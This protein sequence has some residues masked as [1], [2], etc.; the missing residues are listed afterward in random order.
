MASSAIASSAGRGC[1]ASAPDGKL[2]LVVPR[3]DFAMPN[4]LC[5]SPD[6]KLMYIN[7]TENGA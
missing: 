2:H 5:F 1:F 7:D 3:H 6:E 4:G